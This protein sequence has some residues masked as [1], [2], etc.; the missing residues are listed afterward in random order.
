MR[1]STCRSAH[2]DR[3]PSV[4]STQFGGL[5]VPSPRAVAALPR[6]PVERRGSPVSRSGQPAHQRRE[7]LTA[8]RKAVGLS[9]EMFA[10]R[11]GVDRTTVA[12]WEA[13]TS[14]PRHGR[15]PR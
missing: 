9:Q 6:S 12:L 4:E 5:V 10:E 8:R 1:A 13:G 7:R 15:A 11:L 2:R 3:Q 14:E